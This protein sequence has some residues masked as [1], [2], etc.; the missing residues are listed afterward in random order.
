M[1]NDT[2]CINYNLNLYLMIKY[3]K[4]IALISIPLILMTYS[5]INKKSTRVKSDHKEILESTVIVPDH[6]NSV[7]YRLILEKTYLDLYGSITEEMQDEDF[8]WLGYCVECEDPEGNYS[9]D[10][11]MKRCG[12]KVEWGGNIFCLSW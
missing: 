11:A 7:E 12:D 5:W 8:T 9:E 6:I 4:I 2:K 3:H 10:G 1:N